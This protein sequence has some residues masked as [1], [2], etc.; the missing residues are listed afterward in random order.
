MTQNKTD[1]DRSLKRT[2]SSE[3]QTGEEETDRW[4]QTELNYV[5]LEEDHEN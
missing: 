3:D 2:V 5:N 4:R 1:I